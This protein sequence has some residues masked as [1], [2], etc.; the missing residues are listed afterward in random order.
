ML[1]RPLQTF[2][3]S[4]QALILQDVQE[5]LSGLHAISKHLADEMFGETLWPHVKF[6]W[7]DKASP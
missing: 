4:V 1:Y 2:V 7:L 6:V 3:T 5:P